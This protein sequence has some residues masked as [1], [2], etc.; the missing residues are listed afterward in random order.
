[1]GFIDLCQQFDNFDDGMPCSS[2]TFVRIKG[3]DA[4]LHAKWPKRQ[5]RIPIF[6]VNEGLFCFH[7]R[8]VFHGAMPHES[9]RAAPNFTSY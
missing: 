1:M 9:R 2:V 6:Y 3:R 7:Y 8:N 4:V 5:H